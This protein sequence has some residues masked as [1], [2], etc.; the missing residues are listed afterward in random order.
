MLCSSIISRAQIWNCCQASNLILCI[1][2][3]TSSSAFPTT[4]ELLDRQIDS[5]LILAVEPPPGFLP[6][7]HICCPDRHSCSVCLPQQELSSSPSTT[8]L[9]GWFSVKCRNQKQ[10][11]CVSQ[12]CVMCQRASTWV[13]WLFT[14]SYCTCTCRC[15]LQLNEINA[16]DVP[17]QQHTLKN[18]E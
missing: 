14:H 12:R 7:S 18:T 11:V 3:H 15:C 13:G 17:D 10:I 5:N 9:T 1:K 4:L 2:V 6:A 16:V 8:R